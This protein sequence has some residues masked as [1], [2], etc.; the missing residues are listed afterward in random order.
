ML[1]EVF[2]FE[3]DK[4]CMNRTNSAFYRSAAKRAPFHRVN[5]WQANY[6]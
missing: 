6:L 3:A 2:G 4:L 1:A 5:L